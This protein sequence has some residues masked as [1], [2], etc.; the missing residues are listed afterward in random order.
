MGEI[1]GK[2]HHFTK[3]EC[4]TRKAHIGHIGFNGLA[5]TGFQAASE[6]VHF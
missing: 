2:Q 5:A 1:A 4:I 6:I 3:P